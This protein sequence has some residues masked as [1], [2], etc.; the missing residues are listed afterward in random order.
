MNQMTG[1]I[2]MKQSDSE[3]DRAWQTLA[4]MPENSLV[5]ARYQD[6]VLHIVDEEKGEYQPYYRDYKNDD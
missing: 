1:E 4:A 2:P 6:G 5:K 3:L